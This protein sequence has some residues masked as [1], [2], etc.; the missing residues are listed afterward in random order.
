MKKILTLNLILVAVIT[1]PQVCAQPENRLFYTEPATKWVEAL[2]LGNGRL[3]AMVYG[4]V[5]QEHIQFNEETLWTGEPNDYSHKG[6]YQYLDEIR[7]LLAEGKQ[8]EAEKLAGE[9]FMS[10]PLRQKAYQPFGDLILEFPDHQKYTDYSRV[11]DLENAVHTVS[12]TAGGVSYTRE[13]FI[14]H[15]REG[16]GHFL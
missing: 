9:H 6:A 11:L 12:Y 4:G 15:L 10:I 2:P 8:G 14:S 7:R 16:F 1:W 5:S 3:G 13:A